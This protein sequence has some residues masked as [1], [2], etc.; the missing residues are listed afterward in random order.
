MIVV[1]K[2]FAI[3]FVCCIVDNFVPAT[4]RFGSFFGSAKPGRYFLQA[5]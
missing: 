1:E 5:S 3:P 2:S 4:L